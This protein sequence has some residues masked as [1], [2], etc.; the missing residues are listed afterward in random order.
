MRK[1]EFFEFFDLK[2]K[3]LSGLDSERID[4]NSFKAG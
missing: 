3:T 1:D 2:L 4:K